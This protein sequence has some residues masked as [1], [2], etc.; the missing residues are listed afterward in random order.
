VK[1]SQPYPSESYRIVGT[2][3]VKGLS[4]GELS[5]L[6]AQQGQ[7]MLPMLE[8][9]LSARKTVDQVIDHVGREVI[10]GILEASAREV[11]GAPHRG[12]ADPNP[13]GVHRFGS[14]EGVVPLGDRKVRVRKPRLRR[15]AGIN[16]DGTKRASK[17]VDVPAYAAM[18]EH[19]DA[20]E[21][22]HRLLSRGV[23]TRDYQSA[24]RE[25]AGT[26]GV[27]KSVVSREFIER[28][29][30]AHDQIMARRFDDVDILVIYIDGKIFGTH[31]AITALGIDA[32]GNKH[33]L[34]VVHGGSEN[35]AA[36]KTLLTGL[37][38]RGIKPEVPRL[39]I[40]DGSKAIRSAINEVFGSESPVQRCGIHKVRNVQDQ[41]P[42]D[43]RPYAKM[44]ISAA[45]KMAPEQGLNKLRT[46]AKELEVTHPDAAA[47]LREGME[48]LFTVAR[49]GIPEALAKSLRSTNPIESPQGLIARYSRRVK[50]WSSPGMVLRWHCAACLDAEER[51]NKVH[52]AK[53]LD[54]LRTALRPA[55][56]QQRMSA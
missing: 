47:S 49:L 40:I 46:Y 10:G 48:D 7:L 54:I 33:V 30:I 12:K 38:E 6:L 11:A 20:G 19:P 25:M 35:A 22:M 37:V 1:A 8:M 16:A 3:Q 44:V 36:V 31:H 51:M 39:F 43:K 23:S 13:D 2:Q 32:Q 34:G 56:A 21:H 26:L 9:I 14:Q 17:E 45:L 52:G 15:K 28:T 41:L 42:K 27:S 53:H 18:R 5:G 4:E 29:E 55:L 50:N 24:I